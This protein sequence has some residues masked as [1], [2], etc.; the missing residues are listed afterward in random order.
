MV[1][2]EGHNLNFAMPCDLIKDFLASAVNKPA[3]TLSTPASQS[4]KTTASIASIPGTKFVRKDEG[5]EIY[6]LTHYCTFSS[7]LINF[8]GT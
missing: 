7:I 8:A 6:L 3:R 5:Y 1:H 4:P 2:S